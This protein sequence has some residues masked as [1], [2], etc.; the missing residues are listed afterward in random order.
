MCDQ[1]KEIIGQFRAVLFVVAALMV[2]VPSQTIVAAGDHPAATEG[3]AI[4]GSVANSTIQNTVIKQD[5]AV[6]AAM[7]KTF[8]D[9]LDAA[10]EAKAK[11]EA[12]AEKLAQELGFT[13]PA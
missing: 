3:I 7:A 4:G 6:L 2:V 1:H 12:K 10:T 13:K 8:A 5:P 9:Q 11:A